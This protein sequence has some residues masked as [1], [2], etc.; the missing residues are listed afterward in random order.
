MPPVPPPASNPKNI[1]DLLSAGARRRPPQPLA[2]TESVA[3]VPAQVPAPA[4]VPIPAPQPEPSA[5]RRGTFQLTVENDLHLHQLSYHT[6]GSRGDKSYIVNKAL[7]EYLAK[8]PKSREG[9]PEE[10]AVRRRGRR[11]H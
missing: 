6:P 4:L 3:P 9:I 1:D 10:D 8:H 2:R 7:E 11:H 5:I